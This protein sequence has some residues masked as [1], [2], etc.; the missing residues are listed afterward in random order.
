MDKE[1]SLR[2]EFINRNK[3]VNVFIKLREHIETLNFETE[4][5][6][7]L[8]EEIMSKVAEVEKD[9]DIFEKVSKY[10]FREIK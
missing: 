2:E 7:N 8:Y 1:T 4:G 3:V 9:L 5:A 10:V 6:D